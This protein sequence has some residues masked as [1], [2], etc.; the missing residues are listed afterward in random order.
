MSFLRT[1]FSCSENIRPAERATSFSCI[2][3]LT[4][5]V[6]TINFEL[7]IF[8]ILQTSSVFD[9]ANRVPENVCIF[10]IWVIIVGFQYLVYFLNYT[11]NIRGCFI[12]LQFLRIFTYRSESHNVLYSV[13][14]SKYRVMGWTTKIHWRYLYQ[15]HKRL[16]PQSQW[17]PTQLI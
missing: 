13:Q 11:S 6:I 10:P 4:V 9:L 17:S 15:V 5:T 16:H 1:A 12:L 7:N 14:N 8:V 3:D 2:C